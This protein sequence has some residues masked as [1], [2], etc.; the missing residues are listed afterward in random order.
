MTTK[1]RTI[2]EKKAL[3]I[4]LK[5][6]GLNLHILKLALYYYRKQNGICIHSTCKESAVPGRV[7]CKKHLRQ[8]RKTVQMELEF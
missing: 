7:R 3:E 8:S 4:I 5:I 6:E 2:A 1:E